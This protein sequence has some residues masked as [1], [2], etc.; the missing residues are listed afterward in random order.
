MTAQSQ[1]KS[2]PNP[3]QRRMVDDVDKRLS[4]LLDAL[5][6]SQISDT[7]GK[8]LITFGQAL[9]SRDWNTCARVHQELSVS[10]FDPWM[11]GLKR[12]VDLLAR[13]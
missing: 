12:L 13:A 6:N 9:E 7:V 3:A 1:I 4:Q 5:N 2:I 8:A 10:S 11:L